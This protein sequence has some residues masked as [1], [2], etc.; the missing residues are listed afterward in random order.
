MKKNDKA[1]DLTDPDSVAKFVRSAD[2]T[3]PPEGKGWVCEVHGYTF[4]HRR[5]VFVADTLMDNIYRLSVTAAAA[6]QPAVPT[7]PPTGAPAAPAPVVKPSDKD[8]YQNKISHVV[9]FN[10]LPTQT[11]DVSTFNI[12]GQSVLDALV[13]SGGG[14]QNPNGTPSMPSPTGSTGAPGMTPTM[15]TSP[16][17]APG[18]PVSRDAWRPLS[19]FMG[20]GA[21]ANG[22]FGQTGFPAPTPMASSDFGKPKTAA[23]GAANHTRTEFVV[24]FIWKEPTPSDSLRGEDAPAPTTGAPTGQTGAPPPVGSMPPVG[25]H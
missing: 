6:D 13:A 1:V 23:G 4:H 16:S 5:D 14:A 20:G 21:P 24:L 9:L 10:A 12:V 2:P 8:A 15:G 3:K 7:A 11:N 22:A 19:T 17:G 18:G 25:S